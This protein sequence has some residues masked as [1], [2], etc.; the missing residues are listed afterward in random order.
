MHQQVT[1]HPTVAHYMCTKA[2]CDKLVTHEVIHVSDDLKYDAHL[3]NKF[4]Q[5]TI[6][7]LKKKKV[8]ICK[9]VEFT[10]Q[11]TFTI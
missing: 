8:K 7:M 3:V 11:A 5:I 9:I 1:V 6:D 10:D 2:N 4:T